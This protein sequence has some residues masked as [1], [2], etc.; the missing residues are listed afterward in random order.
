MLGKR[1]FNRLDEL[2]LSSPPPRMVPDTRYDGHKATS[3]RADRRREK[4]TV[5]PRDYFA[6]ITVPFTV[7]NPGTPEYLALHQELLDILLKH[8][9]HFHAARAEYYY[10]W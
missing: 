3:N 5:N 6:G 4:L 10:S 8:I 7:P 1:R 2:L 9:P